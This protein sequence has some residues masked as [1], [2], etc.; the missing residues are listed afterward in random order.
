MQALLIPKEEARIAVGYGRRAWDG[1]VSSGAVE[2][3][4]HGNRV[5]VLADSLTAFA[6]ENRPRMMPKPDSSV[7]EPLSPEVPVENEYSL[8]P[9]VPSPL[10]GER[11]ELRR[12]RRASGGHS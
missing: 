11:E 6:R 3:R 9:K 4:R 8:M 10:R 5:F 2:I 7:S 12:R 1:I